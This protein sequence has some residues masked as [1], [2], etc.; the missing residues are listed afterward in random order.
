MKI[1]VK[2]RARYDGILSKRTTQSV[3]GKKLLARVT[4]DLYYTVGDIQ[5]APQRVTYQY[6]FRY[7]QGRLTLTSFSEVKAHA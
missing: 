4:G 2:K 3:D 7:T 6:G 1:E 5:L